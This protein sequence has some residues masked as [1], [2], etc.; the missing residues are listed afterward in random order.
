MAGMS[1]QIG[2][3]PF[4]FGSVSEVVPGKVE[5]SFCIRARVL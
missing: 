4:A 1:G 5:P 2:S 3:P